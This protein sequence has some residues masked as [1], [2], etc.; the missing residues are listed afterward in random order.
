MQQMTSGLII[1]AALAVLAVAAPAAEAPPRGNVPL[2]ARAS[3]A[4]TGAVRPAVETRSNLDPLRGPVANDP[5]A[6]PYDAVNMQP[7]HTWRNHE[8]R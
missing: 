2:P 8:G 4:A 7:P 1:A 6:Y 5:R 3:A